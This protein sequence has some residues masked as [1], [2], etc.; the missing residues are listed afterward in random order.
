MAFLERTY[1][2]QS[3]HG[4]RTAG[5]KGKNVAVAKKGKSNASRQEA[6]KDLPHIVIEK[7]ED[8]AM[9]KMTLRMGDKIFEEIVKVGVQ[10]ATARDYFEI[11][12]L[13]LIHDTLKRRTRRAKS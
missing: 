11:G 9:S 1:C 6:L 3:I 5:R 2:H 8:I 10:V 7:V 12:F 4:S 13:H